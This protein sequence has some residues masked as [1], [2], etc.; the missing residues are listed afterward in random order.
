MRHLDKIGDQLTRQLREARAAGRGKNYTADLERRLG[1]LERAREM[2]RTFGEASF[3]ASRR[4][5]P[6]RSTSS[7]GPRRAAGVA[8]AL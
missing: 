5:T 7:D 3:V 8:P 4:A 6:R 1:Y 2:A